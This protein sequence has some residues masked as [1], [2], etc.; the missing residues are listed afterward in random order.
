MHQSR[1][2][3]GAHVLRR[4][5]A[6]ARGRAT[7]SQW[8]ERDSG[9]G[10]EEQLFQVGE[11]RPCWRLISSAPA[12]RWALNPLIKISSDPTGQVALSAFQKRA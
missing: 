7:R 2:Q 6:C 11:S 10:C 9:A 3:L 4:A 5:E 8:A 12:P 1:H